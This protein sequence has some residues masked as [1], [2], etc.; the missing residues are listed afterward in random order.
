MKQVCDADIMLHMKRPT[1]KQRIGTIGEGIAA[2]FLVKHGYSVIERNYLRKVG[3]ID[4]ICFKDDVLYFVEVKTISQNNVSR[5][6]DSRGPEDNLHADKIRR[7]ERAIAVY[8]DER[9][10]DGDWELLGIMV[11]LNEADKVAKVSLLNDF[12]W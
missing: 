5:E 12:A 8:L 9:Q 6:T 1:E 2:R 3:E 4:I 7:I 11:R 10:V